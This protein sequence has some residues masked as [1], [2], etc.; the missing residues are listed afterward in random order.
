MQKIR[1]RIQSIKIFDYLWWG[2]LLFGIFL[3]IYLYFRNRSLWQDEASLAMN[4]V[5]RSFGELTQA[6][7]YY[8]AAPIGFLF[9][10]KFFI[11]IFGPY[12]YVMRF[13]PLLSGILAIYF[14]Y[15][16]AQAHIGSAG[17][18]ALAIT[19]VSW[20]LVYYASELKQYSSDVMVTSLLLFLAGNSFKRK[21]EAK[22]FFL[23]GFV[24]SLIIWIS[25]P[26]VFILGGI[27]LALFFEK[28][29][30]KE[31]AP[32]GWILGIGASWL[33][34]FGIEYFVS[35]RHIVADGYM[36][37]YWRKAYV[38]SPPWTNKAWYIKT[39][40]YFLDFA[41][42]NASPMMAWFV[43]G[44][45][46]LGVLSVSIRNRK[47]ALILASPFVIVFFASMLER[48]P[49]KNRFI[50][51]LVPL[52]F[53]LMA[54]GFYGVYWLFSKLDR[55]FSVIL[56]T[57]L[58]FFL[59]WTIFSPTYVKVFFEKPVDIRPVLKHV[60]ENRKLDDIVYVFHRTRTVFEYYAPFYG[61]DMGNVVIGVSGEFKEHSLERYID[62]VKGFVGEEGVWYI[63]TEVVTGC[64]NCEAEDTQAFYLDYVNEY[65]EL[66]ETF[67]LLG[68]HGASAYLYDMMP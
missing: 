40:F 39:Y 3:R 58:A 13:F 22:D 56:T 41:F 28:L 15:R 49:I 26:S 55:K 5:H 12:D 9:T 30:R 68:V 20:S 14:I 19:S 54:E 1:E 27:G 7:D 64:P 4:L 33:L 63:F 66:L 51:F 10:E 42:H 21:T 62:D 50:L 48:Y 25:H 36:I 61:L 31:Y 53:L 16:F 43:I 6:L 65:G 44:L 37:E 2:I 57:S 60:A 34:S 67:N 17:L 11:S 24:G 38:P 47:V 29:T 35:L 59:V 32:W 46:S 18:F 52:V 8:Q 23:L 45:S